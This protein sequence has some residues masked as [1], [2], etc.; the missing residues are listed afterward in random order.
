MTNVCCYTVLWCFS[1][2][3]G[4]HVS[5]SWHLNIGFIEFC[6]YFNWC[7]LLITFNFHILNECWQMIWW[8]FCW[9]WVY[10]L[11]FCWCF[12]PQMYFM[13]QS[14]IKLNRSLYEFHDTFQLCWY[15]IGQVSVVMLVE[16][17]FWSLTDSRERQKLQGRNHLL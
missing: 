1:E 16:N 15:R 2:Y 3:C 11:L 10:C 6:T 5:C 14:C 13:V 7:F 17:C 4:F 8:W 9:H 12:L